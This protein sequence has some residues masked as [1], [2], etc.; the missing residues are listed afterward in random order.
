METPSRRGQQKPSIPLR[1]V[2][3]SEDRTH[4]THY[5]EKPLQLKQLPLIVKGK[6]SGIVY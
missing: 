3:G 2:E 1:E 5:P 4:Y 6:R